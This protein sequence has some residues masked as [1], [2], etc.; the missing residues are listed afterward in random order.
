M[1]GGEALVTIG[2]IGRPHGIRG[3]V[4]G[5]PLIDWPGDL[6]KFR[7]FYIEGEDGTGQWLK[8]ERIRSHGDKYIIK[9]TDLNDRNHAEI[10][11]GQLI[12]V[13]E[14]NCPQLP[15]DSY[16]ASDLIGLKVLSTDGKI[17]GVLTDVLKMPAHDI[18]VVDVEGRESLVPAV[19]EF[20]KSVDLNKRQII[21]E[22][23]EGLF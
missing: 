18:Y 1:G 2:K 12:K 19:E 21:V 23:I 3:E 13:D 6:S 16:Y 9:F 11:K 10:I 22:P 20:I 15:G 14:S 4:R 7:S 17:L 5:I 8:L